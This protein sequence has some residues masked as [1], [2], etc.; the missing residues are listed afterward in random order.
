M[1]QFENKLAS[2][3]LIS[4]Q[5]AYQAS[6]VNN[7]SLSRA[8]IAL[9]GSPD[10]IRPPKSRAS[11]SVAQLLRWTARDLDLVVLEEEC[12]RNLHARRTLQRL[13]T[14]SHVELSSLDHGQL[15]P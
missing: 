8:Q 5:Y 13:L 11:S 6:R 1:L 10:K 2:K 15:W 12:R 14:V 9:P 4:L 3:D 7:H